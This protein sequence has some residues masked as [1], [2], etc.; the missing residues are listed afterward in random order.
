MDRYM[1]RGDLQSPHRHRTADLFDVYPE[2]TK[3]YE[4]HNLSRVLLYR[5]VLLKIA[6]KIKSA[7][8]KVSE[9]IISLLKLTY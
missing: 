9:P 8:F 2:T 7:V 1:G 4:V 6:E 5:R 3:I